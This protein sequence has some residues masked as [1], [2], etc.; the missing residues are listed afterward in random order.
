MILDR[1][2]VNHYGCF[3]IRL[4]R[5]R[6]RQIGTSISQGKVVGHRTARGPVV[7]IKAQ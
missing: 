1:F 2:N 5:Q 4:H 6:P 3:N 7:E